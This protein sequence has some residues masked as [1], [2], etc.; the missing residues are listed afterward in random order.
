MR[1]DPSA[2]LCP[3]GSA[4]A[5]AAAFSS[6][7]LGALA[8]A[9]DE[10]HSQAGARL[11]AGDLVVSSAYARSGVLLLRRSAEHGG[12]L[13][14]ELGRGLLQHDISRCCLL[15][16]TAF[17][18]GIP[19]M[20]CSLAS[21]LWHFCCKGCLQKGLMRPQAPAGI[22]PQ[23]KGPEPPWPPLARSRACPARKPG[24]GASASAPPRRQ[25]R[26]SY[27]YFGSTGA[28]NARFK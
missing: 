20:S 25:P 27:A 6:P 28:E 2:S 1:R 4:L 13:Y 8:R 17:G 3:A 24:G 26:L 19:R 14:R 18:T 5:L 23:N 12:P 11:G 16:S 7:P 22:P 21:F 10:G 9:L 15:G